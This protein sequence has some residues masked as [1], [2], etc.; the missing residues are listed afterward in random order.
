MQPREF[1]QVY[2]TKLMQPIMKLCIAAKF[3]VWLVACTAKPYFVQ[4]WRC[5]H[6]RNLF[7]DCEI[8][9]YKATAGPNPDLHILTT[10]GTGQLTAGRQAV[11][12]QYIMLFPNLL[13][14]LSACSTATA[15]PFPQILSM[16]QFR[17]QGRSLDDSTLGNNLV[18]VSPSYR[19]VGKSDRHFLKLQY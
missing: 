16:E 13:F 12:T 2:E 5:L 17:Q 19:Q 9:D 15:H 14:L 1:N 18:R 3:C 6:S 8:C 11:H 4:L 10:H 7:I